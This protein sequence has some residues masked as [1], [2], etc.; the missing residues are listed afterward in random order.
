MPEQEPWYQYYCR[1]SDELKEPVEE[2]ITGT[3]AYNYI[4]KILKKHYSDEEIDECFNSHTAEYDRN[5]IQYH[6]FASAFDDTADTVI[7]EYENC[8]KWDINGAHCD[9]ICEIF[10]K[11]YNDIKK[12][13]D[14]RKIHPKY[15]KFV[16]FFVGAMCIRGHRPTYNWVVQRTNGI[17]QEAINYT[18]GINSQLV[19]ANTDGFIIQNPENFIN[20]STELGFFK[21]EYAGTVQVAE[22]NNYW[23]YQ[24]GD[25]IKGSMPLQLR[26]KV[27]LRIGKT[28]TYET[29]HIK[30]TD[31]NGCEYVTYDY[32]NIEEKNL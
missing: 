19:Y 9:A 26:D 10:P 22:S 11:A 21:L 8:Y 12:L 1:V 23:I 25:E 27:D 14:Q 18:Y 30:N 15:K 32:V 3:Y 4:M 28:I 20:N 5:N 2:V 17:L 31:I 6:Y 29:K 24:A 16:N 13:Y 7:T